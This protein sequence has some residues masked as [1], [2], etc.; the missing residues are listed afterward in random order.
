MH[1]GEYSLFSDNKKTA[2]QVL[3][4][5]IYKY[6]RAK[7]R[8]LLKIELSNRAQCKNAIKY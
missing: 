4:G 5:G 3:K 1:H 8:M 2:K 6:I 7:I